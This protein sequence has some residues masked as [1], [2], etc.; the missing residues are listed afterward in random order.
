MTIDLNA[1]VGESFG[2]WAMGAD[3]DLLP[4]VTSANIACGFHAGDP[5]IMARTIDLAKD[6]GVAIGAHPG[7]P[8]LQGFGRRPMALPPGEIE[9]IVAY[10][11]G[12]LAG[13]AA[14]AG[15][16][17]AH[18][19]PHGALYNRAE[20]DAETAMAIARAVT[21]V[22]RSL[23]LIGGAGSAMD[24]AAGMAGLRF[25]AEGFPDR[26]Y[27]EDGRLVPRGMPGA[28][29]TDPAAVAARALTLARG[30]IPTQSGPGLT[31]RIDTLCVHGD[32]PGAV[33]AA[34]AIRAALTA[35]GITVAALSG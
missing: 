32:A 23:I 14:R 24:G 21:A 1:D 31:R 7:Y 11:I 20:D 12:A 17:L 6:L 34:R 22:D 28:V 35:A 29:I 27:S 25:A 33:S 2:A 3:A 15:V 4:L 5:V 18:V 30:L 10:Q 16:T 26:A 9:T 19:K 8:D 13:L